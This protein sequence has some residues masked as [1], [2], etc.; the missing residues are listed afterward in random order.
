MDA[1]INAYS[2]T[3][4]NH[5]ALFFHISYISTL[6]LLF[7]NRPFAYN[8]SIVAKL[9]CMN[10]ICAIFGRKKNQLSSV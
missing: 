6:F 8:I 5:Y 2:L 1:D 10:N 3:S 9:S 7:F 4:Y